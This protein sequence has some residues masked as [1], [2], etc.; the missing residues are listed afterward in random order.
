MLAGRDIIT[1]ED[2]SVQ[3]IAEVLETAAR[4]EQ[5]GYPHDALEGVVVGSLFFEPSTRTRLSFE[6]AVKRLGGEVSGFSGTDGTSVAKG[7][8]FEDT[9]RIVNGY[10]DAIIVRHPEAGSALTAAEVADVPVINAGDGPADHPTQTLLDLYAIQRTQGTLDGLVV[11]MVGDLKHGRV[12]H[13]L[14]KALSH[15]PHTKQVWV[16][17][18]S[19]RMP[20]D[21]RSAVLGA[22]VEVEEVE[23][24]ASIIPNV[25][26]LYMTR[27]Q[28]ERFTS[29]AEYELVK[30]VY[31]LQPKMLDSAKE[32][33]RVM[34]ALPRR[35]EIPE[36]VDSS[37]HAYYFEQARGGVPVRAALLAAIL[38]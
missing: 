15:F 34:H 11:A 38:T 28:A 6:T 36:S 29:Q 23:D 12:P 4:F 32:N 8:S 21:V 37:P 2:M 22:G 25:D 10:A 7:E 13:S 26:V 27:V 33:M 14:A 3:D 30:D 20:N 31:V 5:E 24:M 19:L 9:I 18:E 35:Y 16:A 1:I 17:P